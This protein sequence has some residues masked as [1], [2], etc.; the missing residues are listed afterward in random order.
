MKYILIL[1]LFITAQAQ[2][3]HHHA[4]VSPAVDRFYSTWF[5]PDKPNQSCC[6]KIDCYSTQARY[7]NGG[8]EALQRETGNWIK[9]PPQKI[10]HNRDNPDGQT[11]VCM[12][13]SQVDPQVLCF[14]L[15]GGA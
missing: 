7:R 5:R 9:V 12:Q 2:E 14:I 3:I 13:A 10:E 6:N 11:H 15:G 4:G 8:W 1:I